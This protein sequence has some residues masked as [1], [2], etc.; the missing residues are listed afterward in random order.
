MRD[1][2]RK[3]LSLFII[4]TCLLPG[5]AAI[6][7]G[8]WDHPVVYSAETE[9]AVVE[10]V[11]LLAAQCTAAGCTTQYEIALWMHN[12]L[13]YNANYDYTYTEYGADGVLLKGTGVCQSYTLAYQLLLE[14]MGIEVLVVTSEEM[15]HA[16]N[17]INLN[18]NWYHVDC[19]WDDPDEGG[20]E[21]HTYFCLSDAMMS[22]DHTWIVADYPACNS[23]DYNYYLNSGDTASVTTQN[24]V[25]T[26][27]AEQY[28]AGKTEFVLYNASTNNM[29][30]SDAVESWWLTEGWK[31]PCSGYSTSGSEYY[32]TISLSGYDPTIAVAEYVDDVTLEKG[33]TAALASGYTSIRIFDH[34]GAASFDHSSIATKAIDIVSS[35]SAEYG[36]FAESSYSLSASS[37]FVEITVEYI[38]AAT[39][40]EPFDYSATGDH[41]EFSY[42]DGDGNAVQYSDCLGHRALL[43]YGNTTCSNTLSLLNSLKAASSILE[44]GNIQVIIGLLDVT[45]DSDVKAFSENYPAFDCVSSETDPYMLSNMLGSY[46]ISGSISL[47]IVFLQ[48]NDGELIYCST[49]F[50]SEPLRLVATAV[51][52]QLPEEPT[53]VNLLVLPANLTFIEESAFSGNINIHEVRFSGDQ[54]ISIGANAFKDCSALQR[55]TIPDSVTSIGEGAFA[56]CPN[57]IIVGTSGSCAE[58]YASANS[59]A[60][61]SVN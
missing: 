31:Y 9:S 14:K 42:T 44:D 52:G 10:K 5:R 55:I 21:C 25:N 11:D 2:Y 6:A 3:L 7:D 51:D 27:I 53:I 54:V 49:G 57:L 20:M 4:L 56:N 30:L 18:G 22:R 28:A 48:E 13:I 45:A 58:S 19:T 37:K 46:G 50:V 39:L 33:I 23:D 32:M 43:V 16:W 26:T 36:C 35:Y 47:P 34:S 59:I 1:M 29:Q 40:P 38:T 41:W 24:E 8:V 12:W 61:E 17:L 15:N 60:F